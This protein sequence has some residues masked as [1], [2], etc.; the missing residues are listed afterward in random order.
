MTILESASPRPPGA[1]RRGYHPAL[2]L[3]IIAASQLMVV[4]V[5]TI[6]NI[7]RQPI[8]P[9]HLFADRRSSPGRNVSGRFGAVPGGASPR[10][11]E[12]WPSAAGW[13]VERR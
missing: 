2:A 6:V 11:Q 4:P 1:A 5:A 12:A 8:T 7:A 13:T 10:G 9:L 3:T